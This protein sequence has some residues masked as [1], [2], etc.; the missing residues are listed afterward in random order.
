MRLQHNFLFH[1]TK[2]ADVK[3]DHHKIWTCDV[4]ACDAKKRVAT[5]YLQFCTHNDCPAQQYVYY[6]SVYYVEGIIFQQADIIV[7]A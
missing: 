7:R 4:R 5:H 1:I 6:R 3:C 2:G